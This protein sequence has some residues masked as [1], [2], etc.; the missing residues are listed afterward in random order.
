MKTDEGRANVR[1]SVLILEEPKV[2]LLRRSSFGQAGK[3]VLSPG[4]SVCVC[5]CVCVFRE[6][7]FRVFRVWS[8]HIVGN[9]LAMHHGPLFCCSPGT[10]CDACR[11]LRSKIGLDNATDQLEIWKSVRSTGQKFWRKLDA[12]SRFES[13][14]SLLLERHRSAG[15]M[16]KWP[17][18]TRTLEHLCSTDAKSFASPWTGWPT[19]DLAKERKSPKWSA[20][21]P[22]GSVLMHKCISHV[23]PSSE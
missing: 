10:P 21:D 17:V 19:Y 5:V 16:V 4:R 11:C 12:A 7:L 8:V 14:F 23:R 18:Y 2:L 6:C 20:V 3:P 13:F 15:K 22:L 1:K 9:V